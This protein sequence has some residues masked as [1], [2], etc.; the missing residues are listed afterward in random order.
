MREVSGWEFDV[1]ALSL[2]RGHAFGDRPPIFA[3]MSDDHLAFGILTKHD[4]TSDYGVVVMRRRTDSVWAVIITQAGFVQRADAEM[5]LQAS[6][7]SGLPREAV[8]PGVEV[9]PPLH[10]MGKRTPSDVF[11]MLARSSHAPA[12]WTLNQLYLALPRPDK[13]WAGDCQT[14][15]FHTR[16]WEAQLLASFREQGLLVTQPFESPDFRIENSVGEAWIEAVTANPTE[17]YNHVGTESATMPTEREDLFFGRASVRFAKTIGNKRD[18]RY[19][20]LAHVRDRPFALAVADFQEPG[21]M[22]WSREA[23]IGYLYGMGAKVAEVNGASVAAPISVQTLNGPSAFPAGLFS[24]DRASELSA[25]VFTNA[26]SLAKLN[27]VAVSGQGAPEGFRYTRVGNFFDRTPGALKGIPFC[28]DVTSSAY[29]E[30]WPHGYEPWCAE[31]EVFHNPFA[32]HPLPMGLLRE[33]THW[34]DSDGER[35]SR[36][37]YAT[38]I[39]WSKTFIQDAKDPPLT[40]DDILRKGDHL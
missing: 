7:K 4:E 26:C 34:F 36:S 19:H 8:P 35:V 39:L 32:K 1:H 9:R 12:A 29:R 15:N 24:D 14:S 22:V 23:L 5:L 16:L 28:M 2:P 25:I 10:D 40:L 30:L 11:K 27:R 18:R 38:S 17:P 31:M 6:L 21:S 20:E 3:W 33:C 13:N 37:I